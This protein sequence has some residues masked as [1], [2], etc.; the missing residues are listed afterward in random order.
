MEYQ[1]SIEELREMSD[2][3]TI[4]LLIMTLVFVAFI[5]SCIEEQY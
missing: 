1:P 5:T 2:A 4:M 3:P